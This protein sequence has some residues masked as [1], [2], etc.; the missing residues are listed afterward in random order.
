MYA[1]CIDLQLGEYVTCCDWMFAP[2]AA[3]S[4]SHLEQGS[5]SHTSSCRSASYSMR[6]N[7]AR[8]IRESKCKQ[9]KVS[10]NVLGRVRWR[11]KLIM[12]LTMPSK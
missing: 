1:G 10:V 11:R 4:H 12:K 5:G 3:A 6:R 2:D 7:Q 8:I 9:M